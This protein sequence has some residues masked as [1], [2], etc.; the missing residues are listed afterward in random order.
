MYGRETLMFASDYPHWD[1]DDVQK[2]HIPP[3]WRA[4]VLGNNAM[5]VYRRLQNAGANATP[6]VET[7]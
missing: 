5:Q 7:A 1:Y 6:T 4:D 3:E 2:L